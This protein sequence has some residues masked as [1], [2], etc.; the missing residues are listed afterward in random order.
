M[1]S[2]TIAQLVSRAYLLCSIPASRLADASAACQKWSDTPESDNLQGEAFDKLV[3]A[4]RWA[5]KQ[6]AYGIRE[7]RLLLL[8]ALDMMPN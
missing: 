7:S 6:T 3:E 4:V 5:N 8:E 1:T 2:A